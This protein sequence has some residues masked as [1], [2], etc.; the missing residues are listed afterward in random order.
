MHVLKPL[1]KHYHRA[2]NGWWTVPSAWLY[3]QNADGVQYLSGEGSQQ[4]TSA[5]LHEDSSR[6]ECTVGMR[7]TPELATNGHA[8]TAA[9]VNYASSTINICLHFYKR[10]SI[11]CIRIQII[12]V[13]FKNLNFV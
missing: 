10:P 3:Q 11:C 12:K 1:G 2:L 6:P 8:T 4:G 9:A 7:L 13:K 5:L